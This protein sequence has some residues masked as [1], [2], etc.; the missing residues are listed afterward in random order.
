[1]LLQKVINAFTPNNNSSSRPCTNNHHGQFHFGAPQTAVT[2]APMITAVTNTSQP[3]PAVCM[4]PPPVPLVPTRAKSVMI[5]ERE[6]FQINTKKDEKG[7]DVSQVLGEG[8]FG[9]VYSAYRIHDGAPVAI[10]VIKKEKV[11]AWEM[12]NGQRVPLEVFLLLRLGKIPSVV[13]LLNW[14]EEEQS[15]YLILERPEPCKDLWQYIDQQ[16]PLAESEAREFMQQVMEM[17][18]QCH[19]AGVIHR[20]IKDEN[21][22][23][24]K[25]KSGRK[26]LKLIDFGAGALL[27]DEAYK[28]FDGGTRQYAPPEWIQYNKYLGIPATVWS[29]GILLYNMVCGD[30]PFEKDH[31]IIA[32]KLDFPVQLSPDC[33]SLIKWCLRPSPLDRPTLDQIIHHPWLGMRVCS[34]PRN[35]P[36]HSY[37]SAYHYIF[38]K[39]TSPIGSLGSTGS[40]HGS[41][42]LPPTP[43]LFSRQEF[44][45]SSSRDSHASTL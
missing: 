6:N 34:L 7:V 36:N 20:D 30:I 2:G 26:I 42:S 18:T 24:T 32:G 14:M 17:I 10:K 31:Q 12:V 19:A 45:S 13:K 25:D 41:G 23:V 35:V 15:F 44:P 27:R 8:G 3:S 4:P 9:T 22:L 28:D 43:R 40:S 37:P 38:G 16:G 29:L 39:P 5:T 11:P 33:E 1:M 21:L